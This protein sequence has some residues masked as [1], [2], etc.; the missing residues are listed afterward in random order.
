M[1][2]FLSLAGTWKKLGNKGLHNA[3]AYQRSVEQVEDELHWK[4]V[5]KAGQLLPD[6]MTTAAQVSEQDC[7]VA[8]VIHHDM[9][10]PDLNHLFPIKVLAVAVVLS[11]VGPSNQHVSCFFPPYQDITWMKRLV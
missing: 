4:R 5:D 8:F 3:E 1:A 2:K 9:I 6:F 7:N 10:A 11:V